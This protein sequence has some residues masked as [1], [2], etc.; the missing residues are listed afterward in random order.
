MQTVSMGASTFVTRR[1]QT[2]DPMWQAEHM[3]APYALREIE[4]TEPLVPIKLAPDEGGAHVLLRYHGRPVGRL[5]LDH[6]EHGSE[7]GPET[8]ARLVAQSAAATIAARVIED[9]L[10][11]DI[12]TSSTTPKVCIAICTRNR[13]ELLRRSLA[14]LVAMRDGR[15]D[16]EPI[17]EILVVDNAPTDDRTRRTAF[18]FD[19]VRY[20]V[21]PV[22]GL[23]LARN[24]ALS[25]TDAP[26]IAYVDD[27]AVVDR[28]W[29]SCLAEGI[30]TAP[31]AGA[32][33]GPILPL[34]LETEAQLRF[35]RAGGFGKGF[36][37][38]RYGPERWGDRFYP[39]SAGRFGTGACMVLSTK[40]VR[41]LGGFDEALDTGPPLPGGGD[42]DM[43][44]RV[45]RSGYPLIYLPGLLVHHQHRRDMRGLRRQYHSW[46][47]SVLA[48]CRKNSVFDPP[49]RGRHRW[50][51]AWWLR[52]TSRRLARALL[53]RGPHPPQLVLSEILG[54]FQGYFGEYRRS[55]ARIAARKR[56]HGL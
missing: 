28:F 13:A 31:E 14:A 11:S 15:A 8:L 32:F 16:Q 24:R 6:A 10:L 7:I 52:D 47:L 26:W 53:G 35:E 50:L 41:A 4:V 22:P 39:T 3:R 56:E 25:E 40:A 37:W 38:E 19:E 9:D 55:E 34:E 5:W 17:V 43:F 30:R 27:D 51:M 23:D 12:S 29:L 54:G 20:A 46:G 2:D 48:L 36:D 49:M 21:E 44:Y 33:T 1:S 18:E 45:V 42:V